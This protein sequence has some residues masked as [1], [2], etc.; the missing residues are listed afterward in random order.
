M[1][2]NREMVGSTEFEKSFLDIFH[3]LCYRHH[4]WQVWRDFVM[5]SACA[6][7]NAVD[8]RS[9]VQK[10]REDSYLETVK[11]YSKEEIEQLCELLAVT[12]SALDKNPAQDFLGGLYMKLNFGNENKGQFFTPWHIAELMAKIQMDDAIAGKIDSEGYISVNDSCCGAGC[13]LMAFADVCK[14][15]LKVNY[16]QS[17]FFVGQDIDPLA[18]M[19]SYIQISLL[20]CPG[21]IVVGNSLTDSIGGTVLEPL[22]HKPE[23][24]W[25]TPL[26]FSDIWAIRRF[27]SCGNF[28]GNGES[29][30]LQTPKEE[31]VILPEHIEQK[32]VVVKKHSSKKKAFSWKDFFTVK[33]KGKK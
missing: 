1:G 14:N 11:R 21:Y 12:V 28:M 16:Q 8:H 7:A 31:K 10:L 9:D 17:V 26:Y 3:R 22:S 32:K 24:I 27:C 20:G 23:D 13:M 2:K 30:A 29:E 4:T 18:A 15:S 25:F 33:G 19:M 5:M 6:I